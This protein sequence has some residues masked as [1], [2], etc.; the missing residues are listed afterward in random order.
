MHTEL[1]LELHPRPALPY[2]VL[3]SRFSLH[4]PFPGHWLL[5]SWTLWLP[6]LPASLLPCYMIP[7]FPSEHPFLC[8]A[9]CPS[10]SHL[11]S[12]CAPDRPSLLK[13]PCSESHSAQPGTARSQHRLA[14]GR[15]GSGSLVELA[16]YIVSMAEGAG[17]G[18]LHEMAV[19][20]PRACFSV[21]PC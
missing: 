9:F 20:V 11:N 3:F 17:G 5:L 19:Q 10:R 14:G 8:S 1:K 15:S 4:H 2:P 7:P 6:S 18:H 12:L 13:T 21:S 16:H